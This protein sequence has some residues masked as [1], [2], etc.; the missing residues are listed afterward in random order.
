MAKVYMVRHGKAAA[1]F[2]G[3]AD[4]GLDEVGRSQAEATA[5]MLADLGPLPI[6][7]SPLA[8][9]RE[10]A[11]PLAERW[12]SEVIIEP[13]VAEIP[14]P[15]EDLAERAAWLREAMAGS[16][17]NL[18]GNLQTWRRELIDCILA[19]EE[20]SVVF[21]HFI[22]I[23]VAVGGAENDDRM[24][25]FSPDNGSVTTLSNDGGKLNVLEL[26]RTAVTQVN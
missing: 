3:H 1:G 19:M 20:D 23:N 22:A 6:Y 2:A 21:C 5:A 10:T 13:R 18:D 24:V 7:S 12:S 26:G 25:I 16:W 14:S 8:R 9:A 11:V 15:T 4:P 17:A